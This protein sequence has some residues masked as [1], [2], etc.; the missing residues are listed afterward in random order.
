MR[1][2]EA[3]IPGGDYLVYKRAAADS[4][5][6]SELGSSSLR[7]HVWHPTVYSP[8]PKGFPVRFVAWSIANGTGIF[9]SRE[10][11]V[12]YVEKDGELVHRSA[13]LP[14]WFRWPF[15]QAGD[16]QISSV[17]TDPSHRGK[18]L[19]TGVLTAVCD[20]LGSTRDLWYTS[21]AE[22]VASLKVAEN[23]GFH[24]AHTAK[25][26]RRLNSRVFGSLEVQN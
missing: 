10:L 15:M 8:V 22:N 14:A 5:R 4:G 3:A 16:L 24:L 20:D 21:R 13:V 12:Y 9:K 6:V 23:A 11:A 17:W 25:R 7:I 26:R 1:P 18:R 2:N 19:A